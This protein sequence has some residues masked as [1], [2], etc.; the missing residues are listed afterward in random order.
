M[1]GKLVF[2]VQGE[3]VQ[4]MPVTTGMALGEMVEIVRGVEAGE[5][6]VLVPSPL[7]RTGRRSRLPA[8]S[9]KKHRSHATYTSYRTYKMSSAIIEI[10]NLS[11]GYRRGNQMIPVLEDLFLDIADGEFLALMGP[12][13]SGKSTLLNLIAGIDQRRPRGRC[14]SA[15]S[16]S[17]LSPR[18]NWRA[19]GRQ[20]SA[21]SSSSTT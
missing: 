3:R 20:I 6:I 19:G 17:P 21:S 9:K 13:G 10:R 15:A 1:A 2:R 8:G 5:K 11:K 18:G 12:S 4:A 14:A 7:W 16:I